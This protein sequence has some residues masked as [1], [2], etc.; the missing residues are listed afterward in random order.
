MPHNIAYN[1]TNTNISYQILL[2]DDEIVVGNTT[3]SVTITLPLV[4]DS[5][6]G[7]SYLVKDGYG[8]A[9][10]NNIIVDGNGA[11]I[12]GYSSVTLADSYD[13]LEVTF[14]EELN[15][16]FIKSQL[17]RGFSPSDHVTISG[18]VIGSTLAS[19]V[20][21]MR[22]RTISPNAPTDQQVLTWVAS[23]SDW[24]PTTPTL[25]GDVTGNYE[26]NTVSKIQGV[27]I[28]GTP[29]A[30]YVL[31]AT[32][33]TAASW[34][35]PSGD[36]TLTGDVTGTA[37]ANI[38]LAID[39]YTLPNPGNNTGVLQSSGTALSWTQTP[40]LGNITV[41]GLTDSSLGTGIV[42]SG[43]GGAFTSSL[44]VNADVSSSAAVAVSKLAAGTANQ[45]L[46]NN[47]TPTP[48]WTTLSGDATNALGVI[49]V[50]KINSASVPAAGS[51]T[52]GNVLQVNGSS[53]LTYA[54]LNLA[55]GANYVTGALP[56]A[57]L[58]TG[59]SAQVLMSN[60]TPATTW[61]TLSGDLTIGATGS[62]TLA[63]VNTNVGTYGDST[64][65]GQFTVNAKGLI[66]AASSV[67]ITGAAPTGSAGGDLSGTYPN[68]T[69]AKINSASVPAA[70]SL[71]TG[72][73]LQVNGASALTYAA[74]NL[75]G[76]ANYVTGNL[77]VTNVAYG[78]ANQ[79]MVTNAGATASAWATTLPGNYTFS[80]TP[81][82]SNTLALNTTG[83]S[84]GLT[85]TPSITINALSAT[86]INGAAFSGTF[87]G[88]PTFSGNIAFSGTPT[89]SNTLALNTTGTSGGLTGSPAITVSSITDSGL[90]TGIVHSGSGGAFTSSLLV[91]ADIAASGTANI[92]VNKLAAGTSAQ[93]LL[94][95]ATPTPTWT[96]MSGD[97][98]ISAT[99]AT[100]VAAIDGY[101]VATP[102][103]GTNGQ[104]LGIAAG[105]NLTWQTVSGGSVTFASDLSGNSTSTSSNQYVS[106]L[107]YSS[108]AGGGAIQIN[109][110]G[111]SLNWA[112][113]NTGPAITQTAQASVANTNGTAGVA[114]SITTQA[115][116][117]VSGTTGANTAGTGGALQLNAGVGGA[118]TG[119]SSSCV[120]G[121]GGQVTINGGAG[122]AVTQINANTGGT[123]GNV[124]ITAGTGGN[125]TN[126]SNTSGN[127]GNIIIS[128]GAA[129][130]KSGSGGGTGSVGYVVIQTGGTTRLT[131][132]AS[133]VVTVANLGTGIVHADSSGNLTSSLLVNADIAASGTANIAVNKLAAGTSAQLLLNNSTPSPTWTSMSGDVTISATGATTVGKIDGYTVANPSGGSN[134]Q[135]LGIAAGNNLTWQTVGGSSVTWASDL[136]GN[137]TST[138]SN[139]Y[140]SSLSYSS[141]S[142]GGA[143]QINGTGTSLV[144]ALG[145]TGPSISQTAPVTVS[146]GA[147][148][149]GVNMSIIAQNGG[150]DTGTSVTAG[151]GGTLVLKGGL[152]GAADGGTNSSGGAGGGVIISSA[153]GGAKSGSGTAGNPGTIDLQIATNS[154]LKI[155]DNSTATTLSLSAPGQTYTL[156]QASLNTNSGVGNALTIQAQN[157]TGTTSTGGALNLTSGT[158]TTA[159][160]AVVIQTGGTTRLTANASGVVTVANLGTGIVHADSS[161]N[162]TSSLLVNADI[163]ASGTANI[164]VNK[165]AAGTSAQVLLNNATP[166]PTWTTLSGDVT[167]SSTGVTTLGEIDGYTLPSP[168]NSGVL[169]SSGTALSWTQSPAFTSPT[170]TTQS[171]DDNSTK[172]ATT[173][174]A[175]RNFYLPTVVGFRDDFFNANT[176]NPLT[177]A[178]QNIGGDTV[179]SAAYIGGNGSV[180]SGAT[181]WTNLGQLQVY[182]NSSATSG[183]GAYIAKTGISNAFGSNAGWDLHIIASISA[184]SIGCIRLGLLKT[185]TA[186]PPTD[187][188]Y[189]EYDTANTGNT[190]T[191]FTWVT[192]SSSTSNYST[193]NA[194]AADTNFHH[195]RIRSNVAGT[196]LFSVDGG[197]EASISTDVTT[198]NLIPTLQI[199]TRTTGSKILNVDFVSFVSTTSRT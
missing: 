27:A 61:T 176:I 192:R 87:T 90:G 31:E 1:V 181:T 59:T 74:L 186:D 51:L 2:T 36:I 99:G 105:N 174:Y 43:S 44:L 65:V 141:S 95:N 69:V 23:N 97:V 199:L 33:P 83:T 25:G 134:G 38:L 12:D 185:V 71:T 68:P 120:G 128:S 153:V 184:T 159:A 155:S 89:F 100:T 86:T 29:S 146:S 162:L 168:S 135:V 108:A 7:D 140:V 126:N 17:S 32:S 91:N 3:S 183:Q 40:T 127:G 115:G 195:F 41:S 136:S 78:T 4:S 79:I 93:I 16:W 85:G 15:T 106:S 112:V 166:S 64:H 122:G 67:T 84:G 22:G 96:S 42:H 102:A 94:N 180:S 101:T 62:T 72:N 164:A 147:G 116:G 143:I 39:G 8:L 123:G 54:A 14:N 75:A 189:V 6:N 130:T 152:G 190:N 163:A 98:T 197:T 11:T 167:V 5:N 18:D 92:A 132:N 58:A 60:A 150:A 82:F 55:G 172:V 21:A 151:A 148:T 80:G 88:S 63:T 77:P 149:A 57:N 196:I 188:I 160:G 131:A 117:A 170:A 118:Y 45:F 35:A 178:A 73:V 30:G 109:G 129:G 173:A 56:V 121:T 49:T 111:T 113:G 125:G 142:A 157:E 104:V 133:G 46:I 26:S 154:R 37:T 48:T 191:D 50:G 13:T 187:G 165:L 9:N 119:A 156:S 107:S 47:A 193:T 161:G 158:G 103:G 169:Q 70:G 124:V 81:T 20:A 28:S 52:T 198:A 145:N 110:T 179:W 114:L 139:Q 76:G 53:S 182:A 171:A 10:I 175:D 137:S 144:W 177:S 66:T 138:S 34:Q 194:I 19:T 24:E